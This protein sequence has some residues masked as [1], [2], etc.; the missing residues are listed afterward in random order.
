LL[1]IGNIPYTPSGF[2]GLVNII[3]YEN[4]LILFIEYSGV[5]QFPDTNH[6]VLSQVSDEAV[7]ELL[8]RDPSGSVADS[9]FFPVDD[10]EIVPVFHEPD[11]TNWKVLN[12]TEVPWPLLTPGG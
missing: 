5:V 8:R 6:F 7:V 10:V 11:A 12:F 4:I 9:Q 1:L 3:P 2:V